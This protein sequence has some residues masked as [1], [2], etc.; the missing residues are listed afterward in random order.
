MGKLSRCTVAATCHL[1]MMKLVSHGQ[2]TILTGL[3]R[4]QIMPMLRDR[5]SIYVI[6]KLMNWQGKK[7]HKQYNI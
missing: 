2:T 7:S 5:A 6:V 3:Y 4:L 1:C